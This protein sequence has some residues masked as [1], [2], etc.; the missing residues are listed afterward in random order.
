MI[1]Q[2]FPGVVDGG[3]VVGV[4]GVTVVGVELPGTVTAVDVAVGLEVLVEMVVVVVVEGTVLTLLEVVPEVVVIDTV[5]VVP[6]VMTGSKVVGSGVV[7][8]KA[9]RNPRIMHSVGKWC[10]LA[11]SI[12]N[13]Q[14]KFS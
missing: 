9:R 13:K 1:V 5:G 8:S 3:G 14:L 4:C 10:L 6:E 11:T 2:F 7:V 12:S